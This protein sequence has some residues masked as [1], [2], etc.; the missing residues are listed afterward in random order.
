MGRRRLP[1]GGHR[2]H[3]LGTRAFYARARPAGGRGAKGHKAK[4][5][6]LGFWTFGPGRRPATHP[7]PGIHRIGPLGPILG[8]LARML[9]SGL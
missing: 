4:P 3:G 5:K 1:R 8:I 7:R 6:G 2:R 9:K